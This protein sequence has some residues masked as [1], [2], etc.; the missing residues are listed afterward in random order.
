MTV[1]AD[2]RVGGNMESYVSY[3][4]TAGALKTMLSGGPE[5]HPAAV[6]YRT[7]AARTGAGSVAVLPSP[8]SIFLFAR[9]HYQYELAVALGM[10][11]SAFARHPAASGRCDSLLPMVQ[12]AARNSAAHEHFCCS[13]RAI[14]TPRSMM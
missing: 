12:R 3:Y 11:G 6:R 14:L 8:A 4:D 10:E 1:N 9:V 2:R 7:L 5:R 13:Q